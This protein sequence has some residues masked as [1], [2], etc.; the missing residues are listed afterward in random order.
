MLN[1]KIIITSIVLL[2]FFFFL[3]FLPLQPTKQNMDKY[4]QKYWD[5]VNHLMLFSS[6]CSSNGLPA[7]WEGLVSQVSVPVIVCWQVVDC[8]SVFM[9]SPHRP[10]IFTLHCSQISFIAAGVVV[11]WT[12]RTTSCLSL[13]K[14]LPG[15][16]RHV[17][18][19]D[20]HLLRAHS[21]A[22][23]S[24]A[25]VWTCSVVSFHLECC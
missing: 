25:A 7:L 17:R 23:N 15:T 1:W 24:P 14:R 9:F 10:T 3:F 21:S 18:L 20:W 22:T 16:E 5:F 6:S 8:C 4:K 11:V 2:W 12:Y 19:M 13:L